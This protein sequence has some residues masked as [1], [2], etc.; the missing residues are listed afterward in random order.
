MFFIMPPAGEQMLRRFKI[1][2]ITDNMLVPPISE[3]SGRRE[4]EREATAHSQHSLYTTDVMFL[5]TPDFNYKHIASPKNESA[6]TM[7]TLIYMYIIC[8]QCKVP[9]PAKLFHPTHATT[10]VL[11]PDCQLKQYCQCWSNISTCLYTLHGNVH[12]CFKE[13]WHRLCVAL[14]AVSGLFLA[15]HG[16]QLHR[17]LKVGKPLLP[18]ILHNII[19]IRDVCYLLL[20]AA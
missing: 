6:I 19:A 20:P 17:H 10:T 2:W 1:S 3:G 15:A 11:I 16:Y 9:L 7:D 8:T 14:T 5:S 12:C 18:C 13:V 4:R